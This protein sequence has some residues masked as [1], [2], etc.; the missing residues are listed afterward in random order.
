MPTKPRKRKALHIFRHFLAMCCKN[1]G[2]VIPAIGIPV[3]GWLEQSALLLLLA[4]VV[5]VGIGAPPWWC[6][7]E[8]AAV[9]P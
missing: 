7:T 8:D 5:V 2:G 4:G 9:A 6:N 3:I 1:V